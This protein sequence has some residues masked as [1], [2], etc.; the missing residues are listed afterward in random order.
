MKRALF[1]GWLIWIL[2]ISA[3]FAPILFAFACTQAA[4]A[5]AANM[6]GRV[7]H[8]LTLGTFR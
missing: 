8:A 5:V 4:L 6:L 3:V 2:A 1:V 7:F